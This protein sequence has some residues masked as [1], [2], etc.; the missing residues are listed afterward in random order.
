MV[1]S[2]LLPFLLMQSFKRTRDGALLHALCSAMF[3]VIFPS[4][5][6]KDDN[7]CSVQSLN[8]CSNESKSQQ[9]LGIPF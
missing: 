1:H 2:L 6:N 7:K 8:V 3:A 9:D 4:H 5:E